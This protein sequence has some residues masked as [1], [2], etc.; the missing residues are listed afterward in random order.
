MRAIAEGTRRDASIEVADAAVVAV[1]GSTL[2][3]AFTLPGGAYA[4]AVMREI[5]KDGQRVDAGPQDA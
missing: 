4:T 5:M 1:D 3:V 2:E